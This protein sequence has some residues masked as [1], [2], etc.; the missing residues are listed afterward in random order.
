MLEMS[1]DPVEISRIAFRNC[2]GLTLF[3]GKSKMI[4]E[5]WLLCSCNIFDNL[6]EALERDKHVHGHILRFQ[7][8]KNPEMYVPPHAGTSFKVF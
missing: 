1:E 4:T 3:S 6:G 8:I 5:G 7:K 2:L